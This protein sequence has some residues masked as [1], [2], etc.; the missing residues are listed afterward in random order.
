MEPVLA[1]SRTFEEMGGAQLLDDISRQTGGRLFEVGDLGELP[2]ITTKIGSALR[3]QYVL[4]YVP[5]AE[6]R[7]GKYHRVQVKII[8][9]KGVPALRTS[10][11]TGYFASA[12]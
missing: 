10:F 4:G 3:N 7:D 11:R 8:R 5:S 12:N 1:R 9:P 2:D 6:R